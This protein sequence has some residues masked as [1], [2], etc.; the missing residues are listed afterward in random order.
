MKG[1]LA[2]SARGIMGSHIDGR[3]ICGSQISGLVVNSYVAA[4]AHLKK[5]RG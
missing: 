4:K 1:Q 2:E 5:S 3:E